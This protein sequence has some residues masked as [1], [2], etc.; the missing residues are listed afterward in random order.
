[1]LGIIST[2]IWLYEIALFI[3][4]IMQWIDKDGTNRLNTALKPITEPVLIPI[5]DK[6]TF[7][8][9]DFSPIVVSL[10]LNIIARA[11]NIL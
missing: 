3:R 1:M 2:L 4:F 11:L 6:V 9:I 8:N 5:R 10:V 7:N